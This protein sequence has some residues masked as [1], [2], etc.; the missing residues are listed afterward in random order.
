DSFPDL[1]FANNGA[2][3]VYLSQ[4][5]AT[6]ART[7]FGSGDARDIVVADLFGDPLPEVV[8][9]YAGADAA[10]YRNTAGVL[11][12]ELTLATG[13]TTSVAAA[14]LNNDGRADLVFGRGGTGN[15]VFINTSST[16]G[17]FFMA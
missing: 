8:I 2:S 6:F 4:G 10:V 5:G 15:L 7:P 11:A 13:A 1:V 9:A 12:L 14:D 3:A 16:K 17:E